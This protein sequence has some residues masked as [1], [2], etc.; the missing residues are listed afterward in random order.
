[1]FN[2]PT[3][4]DDWKLSDMLGKDRKGKTIYQAKPMDNRFRNP[5]PQELE[6]EF[7]ERARKIIAAQQEKLAGGTTYFESEKRFY[8]KLMAQV[9]GAYPL[10][11]MGKLQGEDHQAQEWHKHTD[12]IDY[13]ACFTLKHQIRKYFYFGD[14]MKPAYKKRMFEGAKK[15]TAKDPYRRP[16]YAYKKSGPGW[17]PDVKNSWVDVRNTENLFLMRVTSV[18][19]MAEETG[20]QET[21]AKYKQL[22]LDYAKTLYRVGIGEWDSENYHGHSISPLCNLY[23]FAKDP[24]VKLAAKACLDWFMAAGAVK[25][26]RGGFNGPGSRDYNHDQPFGGSAASILWVYFGDTPAFNEK[27]LESDEVHLITS[28]YRPPLAIVKLARKE[29]KRPVEIVASKPHY[30]ATTTLNFESSPEYLETHY[31]GQNF[32]L[33]SLSCGTPPGIS[34][35]NGFKILVKNK[36]HGCQIVHAAPTADPNFSGSPLY[37]QGKITS[38]NRVAQAGNIAIWLAKDGKAPWLWVVPDSCR[39]KEIEGCTFFEFEDAWI[40]MKPLGM[41]SFKQNL[42]KIKIAS[43]GKGAR[44]PKHS[45]LTSQGSS[46]LFCGMVIEVGEKPMYGNFKDFTKQFLQS[47]FDDSQLEQGV[48]KFRNP[49]GKALGFHWQDDA[50]NL[51]N[52][53]NGKRHDWKRH[54]KFLYGPA[55]SETP[56]PIQAEWGSGTLEVNAGGHSFRCTVNEQGQVTFR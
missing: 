38:Q 23:D 11:A 21:T 20:N 15:W 22:L 4:A 13:Y 8:G 12:G 41:E 24:E 51:G 25:Y 28:A 14:L 29:I 3:L 10:K 43:E 56:S 46:K 50:K 34:S 42:A 27:H 32:L 31:L 36:L 44:F 45:V 16:H 1:M 5:W 6:D 19:L 49:R 48:V 55:S 53:Q 37:K 26:Y 54:Q 47:E 33:G 17:G 40:A 30:S 7:Q 9:I 18:Y 52:W 2:H 35:V 39:T